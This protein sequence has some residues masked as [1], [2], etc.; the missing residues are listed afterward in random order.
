MPLSRFCICPSIEY[1]E[2]FKCAFQIYKL[3]VLRQIHKP[4]KWLKQVTTY[5]RSWLSQKVYI[6]VVFFSSTWPCVWNILSFSKLYINK[7]EAVL[8]WDG[9]LILLQSCHHVTIWITAHYFTIRIFERLSYIILFN[10]FV[11]NWQ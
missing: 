10:I 5:N 6:F 2:F 8:S 1:L 7:H 3:N 9:I 4:H 11:L